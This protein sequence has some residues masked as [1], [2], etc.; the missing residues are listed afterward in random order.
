MQLHRRVQSGT[1]I[2]G[3]GAI[4]ESYEKNIREAGSEPALSNDDA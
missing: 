2:C 4:Q 3:S 1:R